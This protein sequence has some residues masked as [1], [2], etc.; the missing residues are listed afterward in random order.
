M[1]QLFVITDIQERKFYF[2]ISHTIIETCFREDKAYSFI[3]FIHLSIS[4][5]S[6]HPPIHPFVH[7]LSSI[8]TLNVSI[9]IL[10]KIIIGSRLFFSSLKVDIA[11]THNIHRKSCVRSCGRCHGGKVAHKIFLA[12]GKDRRANRKSIAMQT[13][14]KGFDRVNI[15]GYGNTNEGHHPGFQGS[16]HSIKP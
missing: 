4:P 15:G 11:F 5:P 1:I 2:E 13:A 8:Y 14:G 12:E 7:P 9:D 3:Y 10:I 6:V 16:K